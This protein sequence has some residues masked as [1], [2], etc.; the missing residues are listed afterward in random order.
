MFEQQQDTGKSA[1]LAK[2]YAN[3]VAQ[4]SDSNGRAARAE[5]DLQVERVTRQ[6]LIDDEVAR[7]AAAAEER[8]RLEVKA[9]LEARIRLE[10]KA[11]L[12]ERIRL[13]VEAGFEERRKAMDAREQ[14][15]DSREAEV[16]KAADTIAQDI[17]S[18]VSK[19]IA[20]LRARA[21]KTALTRL[22][23][24]FETFLQAL[25]AVMDKDSSK[26]QELLVKYRQAAEE[27]Q[28]LL[29][30]EIKEKLDKAETKNKAKTDQVASLVR[31]L[32]T[33]K[34][35]RVVF[36]PEQRESLYD[37]AMKSLDLT[38][39]T[40]AEFER[41]REYC[42]D[43][44]K[45]QENLKLLKGEGKKKGHGRSKLP[46]GLPR[47][48]ELVI[49]P[50]CYKGHEDEYVKVGEDVQEF[51]LPS[52]SPYV[53]QPVVRPLIRRK[54]DPSGPTVQADCYEG[55]FWKSHATAELVAKMENAKYVLH[56]PFNRQ[57]KKMAQDGFP[58]AAA[59][60]DDWHQAACGMIE[61][62]YELQKK[63][64]FSSMLLAGDGSP[65]PIINSEKHKT[66][67]HYLIQYR[68]VT[69]GIPVFLV[70]T[71]NKCGRGKADI[72]DNLKDWTGNVFM[73]DAYAGY[74]WMK[75]IDGLVLCRCV[76]HA[77]RMAERSLRENPQL[78][79]TAL[80]FYQDPYLVEEI[81]KEK[82]LTGEEKARFRQEHAGPIWETFR[83]WAANTILDVPKDSLIFRAL[84]YLLRNYDELTHYL[85]IPEMPIDNT[86]TERLIRD[87]VMGKKSYL[88]C[89]DLDAC[90][91]AAM[92]YSLFG[93][94]KVLGKN[95]ERWLS[96]VLKN[97]KTTPKDK[98][99]TLLPEFWEDEG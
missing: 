90:R 80:F 63:R 52:P 17:E 46:A 55:L 48:T 32:F 50:E 37:R 22:A 23:D 51:V 18:R 71:H 14:G 3:A 72:M 61:P 2:K 10:V 8:I 25:V 30:D 75:K 70:N 21:E 29:K 44:R 62:L 49:W 93:A 12:E 31:M 45:K 56:Q 98:L 81:I 76:A 86:D 42:R 24:M 94:C 58:M 64:V 5:H 96:Y 73:C 74:D 34:R 68:S 33:Q 9:E 7:R 43:Y 60:M 54:D 67:G 27:T 97:I 15:L 19:S 40:K 26:G 20:E 39:E 11:E 79:Q 66:V 47:L 99:Y 13:E 1:S 53:V 85:S 78:S 65:F 41:C 57:I 92:M 35:E 77:R 69:T 91:R 36:S 16:V 38:P 6:G 89:R 4:L 84:N 88:F 59:T 87:M 95:P 83:A 82:G 28:S